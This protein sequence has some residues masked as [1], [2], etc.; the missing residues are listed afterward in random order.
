MI[1]GQLLRPFRPTK[2]VPLLTIINYSY[3]KPLYFLLF[4]LTFFGCTYSHSPTDGI[5]YTYP[6]EIMVMNEAA[7]FDVAM[8]K[9]TLDCG[10]LTFDK[11]SRKVEVAIPNKKYEPYK[12][13][14]RGRHNQLTTDREERFMKLSI[15]GFNHS[16]ISYN[17]E[18]FRKHKLR[19][20]RI[21]NMKTRR[22]L[23]SMDALVENI[24]L[25]A[26]K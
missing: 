26:N 24:C 20:V 23:Y 16:H 14:H 17:L 10:K 4:L 25:F 5:D 8:L 9:K 15:Y 13:L 21:A 6:L 18:I 1:R 12:S 22:T 19:T 2:I 7:S 3:M 11:F